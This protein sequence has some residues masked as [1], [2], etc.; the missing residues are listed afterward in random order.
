VAG[1][2]SHRTVFVTDRPP[3]HRRLALEAAPPELDVLMLVA[4]PP[5]EVADAV[6]KAEFL[7]SERSGPIDGSVVE[8]GRGLRLIQ[9]LGSQVHDI[10]LEAA[11]RVGVPVC[12]WPLPQ[13]AMV[14]EHVLMQML[15]LAK[16][17]RDGAEVVA[18]VGDWGP[19][20]RCD[21]DTFAINW[22]DR[23]GIRQIRGS[24][25]GIVGFGEIGT[26]L[27][28]RLTSFECAVLY[29]RR[30]RLPGWAEDRLGVEYADRDSLLAR[31]DT[32][33]LLLPH[34][35]E[36][37]GIA[38]ADFLARMRPGALLVSAGASTLLDEEAVADAYRSGR[39]GGIATDGYRWE[40]VRADNPLVELAHDRR[41][42]VVL[43][44]H[45]AQADLVLDVDLRR[46][47]FTNLVAVLEGRPLL[48][49][50]V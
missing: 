21:G 20:A 36:T 50:V 39:L 41:A 3:I 14:A 9:R 46:V 29:N 6:R 31:S 27:A 35:D 32:V 26:E 33:C 17:V 28:R 23:T 43:T 8:A 11:G 15:A 1:G 16:R 10:D 25:V 30:S 7:V 40:P 24:T 12:I 5:D 37:E 38:D 2:V 48:N 49:R 18:E 45:S 13:C 42:N 34:S 44:P 4:P 47:E 22:S 19:P